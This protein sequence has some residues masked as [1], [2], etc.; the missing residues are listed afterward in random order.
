M[1]WFALLFW[2]VLCFA[3]AGIGTWWTTEDLTEW[4]RDLVR[5][6]I[7]PPNGVFGPVWTLL[8]ALMSIAAWLISQSPPSPLR[9]CALALFLAQLG[10]NLAWPF[11]FFR[12]HRLAAALAEVI[13]L[14]AMIGATTLV[15]GQ[16]APTAAW[17]MAPYWAWVSFAVVLNAAFLRVNRRSGSWWL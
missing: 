17:L 9:T 3:V 7:A 5:P 11:V 2:F 10:L 13:L 6:A 4:Y 12:M 8:Y 15:F 1:H 14:W 16:I